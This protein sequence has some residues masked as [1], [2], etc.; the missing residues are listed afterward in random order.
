ME[1]GKVFRPSLTFAGKAGLNVAK[2]FTAVITNVRNKLEWLYVARLSSLVICLRVRPQPN[3]VNH[4]VSDVPLSALIKGRLLALPT[5]I[6]LS[7]K[8]PPGQTL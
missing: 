3:I 8:G 7:W 6:R 4:Y 2:P 1:S 5:N